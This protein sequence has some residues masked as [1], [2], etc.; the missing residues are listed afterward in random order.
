MKKVTK[1][2]AKK[3]AKQSATKEVKKPAKKAV[4]KPA[5]KTVKGVLTKTEALLTSVCKRFAKA[6]SLTQTNAARAIGGCLARFA[7]DRLIDNEIKAGRKVMARRVEKKALEEIF[8]T[9]FKTD[10][11]KALKIKAKDTPGMDKLMQEFA[12]E[13]D[14]IDFS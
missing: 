10:A 7:I 5:R 3:D 2:V 14:T 9:C 8:K 11:V 4:G 1:K 12:K 13:I 6:N